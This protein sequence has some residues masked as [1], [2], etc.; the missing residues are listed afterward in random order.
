MS[1]TALT[2]TP[3]ASPLAVLAARYDSEPAKLLETLKSTVFQQARS[4]DEL[5]ALCI[6]ANTYGLNPFTKEIYAF[7]AK[8]G[9]IVPL[10]SVDGWTRLIN[11]HPQFDGMKFE[12]GYDDKGA[13]R[14][15]TCIMYRK[16]R[17]HPTEV[18]EFLSE[19]RR[20]TDAWKM[21]H[22]MLRHRS[23]I[24]CA[25]LAFGFGGI[26]DEDEGELMRDVTPPPPPNT[27][28]LFKAKPA[29]KAPPAPAP[30]VTAP[31]E[32]VEAAPVGDDMFAA[33][34]PARTKLD[35]VRDWL[36]DEQFAGVRQE[37]LD[38]GLLQD[39]R[40]TLVDCDDEELT[41]IINAKAVILET[42]KTR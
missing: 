15:Y 7:P 28:K 36:S 35:A 33:Q 40:A 5:M 19:C 14:S 25:R 41:N 17:Q 16:D 11:D 18:T 23:M 21:E 37:L 4:N 29:A 20:P 9:G 6:V 8:G 1:N 10:V 31:V 13:L 32:V 26:K 42:L 39:A 30:V 22:R 3:K 24:Q 34:V 2:T 27:E 38:S 12:P